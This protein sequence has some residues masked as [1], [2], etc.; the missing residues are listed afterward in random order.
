MG[1]IHPLAKADVAQALRSASAE[2]T[3]VLVVGG[4]QHMDRGDPTEAELEMWTTQ[5]D[6]I[7]AYDPA[8]MIVVVQGGKRMADLAALLAADGQ[9]W[10]VDAPPDATVGGIIAA[11]VSSPRR[12]R[13]GHVRDTVVEIELVTGDGRLIRSGART[14]KNVTGYD[15]HRLV[16]GSLGTLGVIVQAALRVRPLPQT[17]VTLRAEGD[18]LT[19]GRDLLAAVPM[20]AGIAATRES[21]EIRLE[22]WREEVD[23]LTRLA[24]DAVPEL[25]P[26]EGSVAFP[27]SPPWLEDGIDVVVEAAVP[28]S[29]VD[30]MVEGL[31]RWT[32][33]IGVGL[34]WFELAGDGAP[35]AVAQ[36]R[37]RAEAV[38]G[39]APVIKGPGGRGDTPIPALEVHRR[40]KRAFDPAGI[41]APGRLFN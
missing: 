39:I 24:T 10:P 21:V 16:T 34:V 33:L 11:G 5:L 2:G 12:L 41:M 9:E 35:E 32:T 19:L 14:V 25:R 17:A 7:V 1:L 27:S 36:I 13:V 37:R 31:D 30:E 20:A 8:E 3:S 40:L 22:G 26:L 29:R 28:P 18:G 4:R 6:K 23:E 38:G 15:V